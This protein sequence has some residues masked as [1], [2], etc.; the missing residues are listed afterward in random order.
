MAAIITS[1]FRFQAA[2]NL[3]A[4]IGGNGAQTPESYYL[5]VGRS[6]PWTG[7]DTAPA[8]P[9]DRL[10]DELDA[11]QN[12]LAMKKI[13][14][15][16]VSHAIPR[17]NWVSGQTYS[18]YDDQDSLLSAKQ[19][20]VVT[21]DL[22]VYK[23]IK[24]GTS[25]SLIRPSGSS[26]EVG[27]VL[28]DGYQW[29]Y[30][31][32]LSGGD[33]AKFLT[34]T[35]ISSKTLEVDDES[36]QWDV[37]Q[38]AIPG[39]IHRIKVTNGGSGYSASNK[40]TVTITGNGTGC[41]V[42]PDDIVISG[43]AITEILVKNANVGTGYSHATVS[44]TGGV[45]TG[46]TARA[47]IS[48]TGGHG[49][50]PVTELSSFYVM[51]DVQ[52]VAD[53]GSGDFI[54]DNEF[55]QIGII[56]NP[57]ETSTGDVGTAPTYD[58]LTQIQFT[59]LGGGSSFARDTI[60][61]GQTSLARAYIDSIDTDVI[62]V[63]Q[64]D[65]TGFGTFQVGEQIQVGSVYATVATITA[66]EIDSNSGEVVYLENIAPVNRNSNQTEDIKLVL[67]L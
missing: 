65:T 42:Q 46:A 29:K 33:V 27:N 4:A 12:M 43:G 48:P 62:R 47:V 40:P 63:H 6:M 39:A 54:V 20:Y 21:D 60:I 50:D 15:I 17:Y 56:R 8:S 67:E 11:K 59:G 45:G 19:Y 24:A 51:I 7:S 5:F 22:S 35:F 44:I 9:Q 64:N 14:P 18:E 57:I 25:G 10:S 36:I 55:R 2:K 31:F 3:I 53:D 52:L 34:S 41:V 16:G 38:A 23:C 13:L 37:Q 32:T 30:M 1:K 49:S 66:P 61:E 58:A 28:S 26:L